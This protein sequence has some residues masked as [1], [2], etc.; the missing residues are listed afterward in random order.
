MCESKAL[1]PLR[2][3]PTMREHC[4]VFSI[5]CS[6][7]EKSECVVY[8]RTKHSPVLSPRYLPWKRSKT[9]APRDVNRTVCIS[10]ESTIIVQKYYVNVLLYIQRLYYV[11]VF[12]K[13]VCS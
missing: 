9:Y 13:L 12:L 1:T 5:V 8:A 6:W 11:V 4:S 10:L 2:V 7:R 3:T